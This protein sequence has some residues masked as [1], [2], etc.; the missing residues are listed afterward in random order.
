MASQGLGH[1]PW[2]FS[3]ILA[4]WGAIALV[5][6]PAI[7]QIQP[8][9]TLGAEQSIVTPN[10][11]IKGLPADLI[12]GG[13]IRDTNLFHS[14]LEFNVGEGGRVYFANPTGIETIF[15]RVTGNDVSNILGTLG[16]N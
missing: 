15:S 6:A 11:D 10:V 5:A 7:A 8:D 13:A 12:E 4:G 1:R 14:F 3:L 2:G 9:T 16:V